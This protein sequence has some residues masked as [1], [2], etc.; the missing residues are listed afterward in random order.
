MR[1]LLLFTT[2]SLFVVSCQDTTSPIDLSEPTLAISDAVHNGANEHFFWLPPMV[3]NPGS[4]NG[5]FDGTVSPTVMICNLA[6]CAANQVALFTM[7]TGHGSETVRLVIED[8]HY[9]VNWHTDEFDVNPG[10]TYRISVLLDDVELGFAD[11][12]LGATGKE[13]KNLN[14]DEIIALKDGR[15]LPIKF[16]IEEGALPS[17]PAGTVYYYRLNSS[18]DIYRMDLSTMTEELII[19]T[20]AR[21]LYPIV[22]PDGSKIAFASDAGASHVQLWIMNE[23]GSNASRVGSS[24]DYVNPTDWLGDQI[25][26]RV[27]EPWGAGGAAWWYSTTTNTFTQVLYESGKDVYAGRAWIDQSWMIIPKT[28]RYSGAG[29]ELLRASAD[30]STVVPLWSKADAHEVS[31]TSISHDGTAAVFDYKLEANG[32]FDL[33]LYDVAT[34]A[35]TLLAIN[36]TRGVWSP[37]DQWILFHRDNNLWVSD[38]A[39]GEQELLAD[40]VVRGVNSWVP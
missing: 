7:T 39:G 6:D 31:S 23:D 35:V 28:A 1:R 4:I 18:Y 37:D 36:A 14:T 20:N 25:L 29:G 10:L 21:E 27:F 16:R 12:Q 8:E 40:G 11:V 2:L 38:L 15:T 34:G 32:R 17:G 13:V 30:G 9:I 24:L 22:S 19:G 33:Y 3:G 5:A 26:L